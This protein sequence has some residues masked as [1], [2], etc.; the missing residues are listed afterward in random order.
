MSSKKISEFPEL[1]AIGV[2]NDD[3]MPIVNDETNKKFSWANIKTALSSV[4]L[5]KSSN[6]SDVANTTTARN[7]I[8]PA[9][10]GN[11]L[12]VL[13]VNSG[14]TDYELA[15]SSSIIEWGDIGGT[16]SD[17]TDLNS[18]LAAKAPL[19][20]PTFTGTVTTP[21]IIVSSETASRI[22]ILDS[23]KNIKSADIA[24]YPSLTELAYIKGLS[25][26]VQTQLDAKQAAFGSQTQNYFYAAPDGSSGTPLFRAIV[27]ADIP[28]LNQ[29]TTGSAATLTTART[30]DGQSFD[31]SANIT[32]IAP[33][34]HA[35]SSKTTPVDADELP[36][37]DSAASNVLKK[38]TWVNVKATLKSYFDGL[39]PSGSGTST[40]TNTGDQ[41]IKG[42]I[43][44]TFDGLGNL[45]VVGSKIYV[46]CP[47]AGT[48]TGWSIASAGSSPTCTLDVWKIA[49]GTALPT[50]ANTIMGTKPALSTGNAKQSTTLTGWTTSISAGDIIAINLDAVAVSTWLNFEIEITKS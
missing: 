2:T 16:L 47:Y 42:L 21:A 8:L 5:Q 19:A 35:A 43:S 17:Q 3:V 29:N 50:V 28:T 11:A 10:T 7:N 49:T 31:G 33:G 13:R 18:A 15:A 44:A 38:L 39:Y 36:L 46:T 37:V 25:S 23:S 34:T 48:I 14:E 1:E 9:K 45:L 12:K 32:V 24:T 41:V 27:A 6:L 26:A 30:I 22:A 4:F 40:G 20:S